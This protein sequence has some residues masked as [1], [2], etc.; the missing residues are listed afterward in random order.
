MFNVDTI[1]L[2]FVEDLLGFRWMVNNMS[3]VQFLVVNHYQAKNDY[4]L[5]TYLPNKTVQLS[6]ILNTSSNFCQ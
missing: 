4:L 1:L 6:F 5:L 2:G 3:Q